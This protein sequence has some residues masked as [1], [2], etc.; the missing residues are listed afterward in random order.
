MN[1]LSIVRFIVILD[2]DSLS[3]WKQNNV[4]IISSIMHPI[5]NFTTELCVLQTDVC[6]Y[7]RQVGLHIRVDIQK[8]R[9]DGVISVFNKNTAKNVGVCLK[10][11]QLT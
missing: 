10:T 9:K 11:M 5:Y 6:I 3:S 4:L 1:S 8:A 2:R 7:Q